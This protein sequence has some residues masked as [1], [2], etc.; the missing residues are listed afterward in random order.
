MMQMH[1]AKCKPHM[2]SHHMDLTFELSDV[3]QIV[4]ARFL[5]RLSNLAHLLRDLTELIMY[6]HGQVSVPVAV[7]V[8]QSHM[9]S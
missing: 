3:W 1:E 9:L 5:S 7:P 4:A 2:L 6:H 8:E